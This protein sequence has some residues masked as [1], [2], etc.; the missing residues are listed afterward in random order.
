[1]TMGMDQKVSF[2]PERLPSWSQLTAL[3]AERGLTVQMRMIDGEL[4]FPDEVPSMNW[5]ELRVGLAPGMIT[6]RRERDGITL[7]TWGNADD[8]LRQAWN[9][10]A[11]A[12]ADITGGKRESGERGA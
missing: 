10:L 5:R 3:L 12:L 8:D 11:A 6:L 7:V 2:A 4:A 1:M 9:D